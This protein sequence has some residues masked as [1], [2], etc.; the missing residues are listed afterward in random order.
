AIRIAYYAFKAAKGDLG[1]L[2]YKMIVES[3][4]QSGS[5]SD[6]NRIALSIADSVLENLGPASSLFKDLDVG[7][8]VL[9]SRLLKIDGRASIALTTV[10][11]TDQ[12]AEIDSARRV[13]EI[14]RYLARAWQSTPLIVVTVG[15]SS[16]EVE[17][18]LG[19]TTSVLQFH[20]A[21]FAGQLKTKA[22]E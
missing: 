12:I 22:L 19:A 3:A 7:K 5:V 4:K 8:G 20:E 15:Y 6:R 13:N 16:Q 17:N 11:A 18:L 1:M 14:R 2:N 21:S 10:K 9:L